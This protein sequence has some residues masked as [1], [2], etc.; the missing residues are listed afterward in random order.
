[1]ADILIIEDD[2]PINELIKRTLN[3]A[4]HRCM[5]VY[6]G[7]DAVDAVDHQEFDLMLLDV[8]L[9]D[10]DGFALY[11]HLKGIPVIYIT[12]RHDLSDKLKGFELGAEDYIVKPFD[13]QEMMARVNVALRKNNRNQ[14]IIEFAHIKIDF[15]K[16]TVMSEG[17]AVDLSNREFELMRVLTEHRNMVLSREQLL[18]LAWGDDYDG[19]LRTV[20]VHIRRLRQKLKLEN[21][22]KT[23]FK[24]GYRLELNV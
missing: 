13:L 1:M 16:M 14:Q 3:Q 21:H 9:P 22:I 7:M 18:D 10:I 19:E 8:N 15:S 5:Q 12:A 6:C 11:K 20:D 4:G 17:T 24:M 23:V 2:F